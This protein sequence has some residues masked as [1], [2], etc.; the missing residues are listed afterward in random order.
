[1]AT[2]RV[3]SAAV[4]SSESARCRF[5]LPPEP[6]ENVG[7]KGPAARQD[8][9]RHATTQTDLLGQIHDAHAP[10]SDLVEDLEIA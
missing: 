3:A 10:T 5:R 7:R 4:D 6:G 8:L 9:E 2:A 1:M